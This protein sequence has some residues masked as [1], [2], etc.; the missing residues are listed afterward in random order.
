MSLNS[1]KAP[2]AKKGLALP[3][4]EEETYPARLLSIVDVGY[5]EVFYQ[6]KSKGIKQ[7]VNF[8]FELVDEQV[9]IE[10]KDG[11][12]SEITRWVS[13]N[14]V[15]IISSDPDEKSW[16]HRILKALDPKGEAEGDLSQLL[17]S[18]LLIAMVHKAIQQGPDKGRVYAGVGTLS[19][20]MKGQEISDLTGDTF[21]FDFDDADV[22]VF[23]ALPEFVQEKIEAATNFS[24]ISAVIFGGE[25]DS[26]D[27]EEEEEE[28]E[29][30][31]PKAKA[32]P[33]TKPKAKP[34]TKPKAKPKADPE[35]EAE[36]DDDIPY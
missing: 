4:L 21:T 27:E 19:K 18:A 6:K 29:K 32:K 16:Q 5:H 2:E 3:L 8:T 33:K 13:V 26:S 1:K 20:P 14:N 17:G 7:L 12:E 24:D 10:D 31:K 23:E 25:G 9:T 36:E 35:E 22:E 11:E 30:P 34:K 28:E 15:S